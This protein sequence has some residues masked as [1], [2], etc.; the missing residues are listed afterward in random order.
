MSLSCLDVGGVVEGCGHSPGKVANLSQP[1]PCFGAVPF[2]RDRDA[3]WLQAERP[4][5]VAG[6]SCLLPARGRARRPITVAVQGFHSALLQIETRLGAIPHFLLIAFVANTG[7]SGYF[8]GEGRGGDRG[9]LRL[10][11]SDAD[12]PEVVGGLIGPRDLPG[13]T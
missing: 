1:S 5:H 11:H 13:R 8:S 4:A 7:A 2:S 6:F 9:L 10:R 12:T 3:R